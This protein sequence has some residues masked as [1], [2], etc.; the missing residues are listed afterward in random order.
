MPFGRGVLLHLIAVE[1]VPH[2]AYNGKP[3][4]VMSLDVAELF[5]SRSR[6]LRIGQA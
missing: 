3:R 1:G 4:V 6:F 5:Q 2:G